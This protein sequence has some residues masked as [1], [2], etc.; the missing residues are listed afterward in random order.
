MRGAV[1]FWLIVL[2]Q[3]ATA[4]STYIPLNR[5][6]YHLITRYEILSGKFAAGF[7]SSVQPLQ[8]Q[9]VAA[10][11]DSLY[12]NNAITL[13]NTDRFNLDYISADNW[14]WS[15]RD[16]ADSSKPFLKAF[17]RKKSD[18]YHVQSKDF[19][20]HVNP[21]FHFSGGRES[22]SDVTTYINTRGAEVRGLIAGRVGF[23]SYA[24]TTQAA[25]PLY[26][27][28]WVSK[29][30]VVPNEGFWKRFKTNGVDYFTARGHLSFDLVKRYI[31]TQ[32]GFDRSFTGNG[33]RSMILSDFSPGY[34][35][36]R[37]NTNIWR[38]NYTNQFSQVV[39]D[40]Y[41]SAS[42]SSDRNYPNKFLAS[43]HLSI[44]ITD[45]LN[46][47]FFETVVIGDSTGSK[48]DI[49]YLNPIIFYRALEHQGGSQENVI[50]GAD[51]KWNFASRF[52]L[53]GQF[54]LDEFYLKEIRAGNGWWANKIGGQIGLKYINMFGIRNLDL[55]FE[56]NLARPYTYA[57]QDVF[58]NM[59]HYRQPLAHPLGAN[60]RE[61]VTILRYQPTG[62]LSMYAQL[63]YARYGD[64]SAGSNWGKN[65]ML[66]YNTREQ[67]YGNTI[68]QGIDTRLL[69]GDL[70]LTYQVKHNVFVDLR[71]IGRRR[72]S[73]LPS[74]DA[75]TLYFTGSFRWNIPRLMHDF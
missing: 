4:Q 46:I 25:F 3:A 60:F 7:H 68:G 18:L 55:V 24:T 72:S 13:N 39:A 66:S 9:H 33:H 64:D 63:N 14:A 75:N 17:F 50:V 53:Y 67:D 70:T 26:V 51:F 12:M 59:A 27:R 8:R 38:I 48:F 2:A 45:N 41:S 69:Y 19:I 28:D 35:F 73:A 31:N 20:L 42:G 49:S 22:A 5:D 43:H 16:V 58:S 36:W 32:V 34:T 23:Y 37:I 21:V 71:M 65:I 47:G 74:E 15:V 44:N 1:F 29:H 11:A 52:S 30:G 6:Y 56:H 40:A 61:Y 10:F 62:R 54:V 57:H